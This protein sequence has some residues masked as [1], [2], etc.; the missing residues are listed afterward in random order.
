MRGRPTKYEAKY[1]KIV[2]KMCELGATVPDIAYSLDVAESTIHL[3]AVKHKAFSE[4][5]RLGREPADDRV[6]R[7]LY[8]RAIGYSHEDTDIK[9]ING[10]IVETQIIKHYPPDTRAAQAWLYNR[11]PEKWHPNP[12]PSDETEAP[13]LNINFTVKEAVSE[14]KTTNAKPSP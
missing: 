9:V 2:Q 1:V 12:E 13:S 11:R 7:A 5:L 8:E 4:A 6:E 10:E 14:V 3:W